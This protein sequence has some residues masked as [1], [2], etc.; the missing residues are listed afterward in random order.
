MMTHHKMWFKCTCCFERN[1]YCN[2]DSCTAHWELLELRVDLTDD[3][4]DNSDNAEE[5]RTDESDL[6][7]NFLDVIRSGLTGSDTGDTAVWLSKVISNL[8]RI[9]LDRY[10]EVIERYDKQEVNR[11]I[12]PASCREEVA[13]ALVELWWVLSY[14]LEKLYCLRDSKPIPAV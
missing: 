5:E 1:A 2:E 11:C 4:R 3:D 12:T 7:K 8:D 9:I 10:I 13:E 6:W 14:R